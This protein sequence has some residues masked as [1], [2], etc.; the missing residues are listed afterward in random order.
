MRVAL[1][2]GTFHRAAGRHADIATL[3]MAPELN[4]E[5]PETT[6]LVAAQCNKLATVEYLHSCGCP[7][8]SELVREAAS[9]GPFE[10]LRWC[11]EHGCPWENDS[12]TQRSAAESGNVELMAWMLQ[13]QPR[14]Q[15]AADAMYQ[16]QARTTEL[17]VSSCTRS[18][19]LGT[20]KH[21][22][23]LQFADTPTCYAG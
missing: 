4:V 11:C 7:C 22:A 8:P 23:V 21:H 13:Q 10:L 5:L 19:A 18:S 6:T 16:L 3:A 2:A 1:T 15:L 14:T 12:H 9:G 17:C 20:S